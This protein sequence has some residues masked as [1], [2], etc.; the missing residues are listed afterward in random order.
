MARFNVKSPSKRKSQLVVNEAGGLAYQKSTKMELVGRL[1]AT[2]LQNTFY[3]SAKEQVSGLA[4]LVRNS[5]DLLFCAKAAVYARDKYNMRSTSHVVAAEI[6]AGIRERN[7]LM[8]GTPDFNLWYKRFFNRVVVR[9]DDMVEI[10][11]YFLAEHGKPIPNSLKKGFAQAFGRFDGYQL[12]K[13]RCENRE[14]TLA[15]V[16]KLVWPKVTEKNAQALAGLWGGNLVS[17]ETWETKLSRA[18]ETSSPVE[19][20]E[21]KKEV[22]ENLINTGKIGQFALLRNLRNIL[23]QAPK[24]VGKAAKLLTMPERVKNSRILPFRYVTAWDELHGKNKQLDAALEQ[25]VDLSLECV[26]V[27]DGKTLI[28]LDMSGSMESNYFGGYSNKGTKDPFSIGA[29]FAAVLHRSLNDT[30]LIMFS[31]GVTAVHGFEKSL[32]KAVQVL[33]K[34]ATF[35]GTNFHAIFKHI[36]SKQ[37][38]RIV[39]LSDQEAWMGRDVAEH[40]LRAYEAAS[41]ARPTIYVFDLAGHK[42]LQFR[43]SRVHYVPGFSEKVFDLM[44]MMETGVATLEKEINAVNF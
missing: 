15:K 16:A 25:A 29:L 21:A 13:Y 20:A 5:G 32:F 19:K 39:I 27:M 42:T 24:A 33:R 22:W 41:G 36:G 38:D 14:L 8:Q 37:Y 7:K 35:G 3:E 12:A 1:L 44:A 9:P 43:E 28:A 10:L 31:S 2:F 6:A 34:K 30:D 23:E 40:S 11:A 26:P 4:E 17:T 18:G